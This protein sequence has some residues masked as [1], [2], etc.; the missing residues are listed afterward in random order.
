MLAGVYFCKMDGICLL[1]CLGCGHPEEAE[2]WPGSRICAVPSLEPSYR[3]VRVPQPASPMER[4]SAGASPAKDTCTV[5][6]LFE[7][8]F[9]TIVFQ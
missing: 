8:K 6:S 7:I 3:E 5:I 9:L 1:N 2:L 4:E